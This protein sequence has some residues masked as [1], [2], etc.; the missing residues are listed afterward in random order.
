MRK[1]GVTRE[2][3]ALTYAAFR[4]VLVLCARFLPGACDL[5]DA[6]GRVE[7]PLGR[8]LD[9]QGAQLRRHHFEP[10]GALEAQSV[11][12]ANA[13][14]HVELALTGRQPVVEG[15]VVERADHFRATVADLDCEHALR[16]QE[17]RRA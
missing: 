2:M 17:V 4:R 15:V 9:R 6:Y 14:G 1:G 11:Q 3:S 12:S 16:R 8:H 5:E 7:H 13:T 10:P